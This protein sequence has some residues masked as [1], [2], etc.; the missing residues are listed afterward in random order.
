MAKLDELKKELTEK[1]LEYR[2][3]CDT[4]TLSGRK[5]ADDDIKRSALKEELQ[6]LKE[7]IV[8]ADKSDA[9]PDWEAD[10]PDGI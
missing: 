8:E 5:T 10:T 4:I 3:L 7:Q 9:E 1:E 6:H 2:N